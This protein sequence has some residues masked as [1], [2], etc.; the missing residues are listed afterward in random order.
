M[1][2]IKDKTVN[3]INKSVADLFERDEVIKLSFLAL[4]SGESI[5]LLGPP[6]TAKSLVSRKLKHSLLNAKQ[7]EYLMNRFSTPEEIFGPISLKKLDNDEYERRVD[8]FLPGAH[9]VFLD[10]IWKA[11]PAIQNSLLTVLNEKIYKN[12]RHE[13]HVPLKLLLAASNELPES[14]EGLEAIYDRFL[15]RVFVGNVEK[16][17]SFK[18]LLQKT[19]FE[20]TEIQDHE[21]LTF[22]EIKDVIEQS[23]NV[24]LPNT[25][26]NF[27]S[28]FRDM[29]SNELKD[30]AP[31]ISDRRWKK[32][33]GV[34]RVSATIH[35]REKIDIFDLLLIPNMIWENENQLEQILDI[36]NKCWFR[37]L[38]RINS[39]DTDD[40]LET[41]KSLDN[42]LK[43][44]ATEIKVIK[45]YK[46]I[47]HDFENV[48]YGIFTSLSS[49]HKNILF[50]F[51]LEEE[52]NNFVPRKTDNAYFTY[53]TKNEG[54]NLW[55]A[56]HGDRKDFS[57]TLG[58]FSFKRSFLS[59][60]YE[61]KKILDTTVVDSIE[62]ECKKQEEKLEANINETKIFLKEANKY[63]NIFLNNLSYEISAYEIWSKMLHQDI[64]K[65]ISELK[66]SI[67]NLR[68]KYDIT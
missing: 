18:D 1:R 35:Q 2:E 6:G 62:T 45:T 17:E 63:E 30:D 46:N 56:S 50:S 34:L 39:H 10:E 25:I 4:L 66:S 54:S 9:V 19:K 28:Y 60:V 3:L 15:I 57:L 24:E 52:N 26:F 55:N 31:Y 14:G 7:F 38:S 33:I 61:D 16:R 5:F 41:I 40:I 53:Y 58:A 21:K 13:I 11:S 8:D 20:N 48:K 43:S 64:Q 42:K 27:I 32:I 59:P 44:T 67:R 37:Q 47:D 51:P 12:G 49:S 22:N 68:K 36:F 29:L 65:A 23:K